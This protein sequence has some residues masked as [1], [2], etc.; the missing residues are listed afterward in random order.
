MLVHYSGIFTISLLLN[1]D[2]CSCEETRCAID[3]STKFS[4]NDQKD[5][6]QTYQRYV[7]LFLTSLYTFISSF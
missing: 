4:E 2:G 1:L 7:I 6:L 5:E 3:L